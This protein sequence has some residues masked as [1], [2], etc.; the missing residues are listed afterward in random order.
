MSHEGLVSI[1]ERYSLPVSE[2]FAFNFREQTL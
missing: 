2:L 1:K